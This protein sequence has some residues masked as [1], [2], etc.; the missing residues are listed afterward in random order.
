MEP[1][2]TLGDFL[3]HLKVLKQL[4]PLGDVSNLIPGMA[5]VSSATEVGL[6]NASVMLERAE[7]IFNAMSEAEREDPLA[8]DEKQKAEIAKIAG[9]HLDDVENLL[10]QF[11]HSKEVQTKLDEID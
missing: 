3:E 6:L 11:K 8:L 9:L 5:A 10:L 1:K 4:G 2:Y 7:K